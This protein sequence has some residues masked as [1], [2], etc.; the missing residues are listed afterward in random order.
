MSLQSYF[1]FSFKSHGNWERFINAGREQISLSSRKVRKRI[2]GTTAQAVS[3]QSTGKEMEHIILKNLSKHKGKEVFGN[4]QQGFAKKKKMLELIA[5]CNE[6]EEQGMF[7]LTLAGV[8][9]P[10]LITSLMI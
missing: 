5:F 6:T 10:P 4:S 2:W 8:L 1:P 7:I 3:S 9:T